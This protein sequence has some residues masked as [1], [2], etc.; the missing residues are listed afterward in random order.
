VACAVLLVTLVLGAFASEDVPPWSLLSS[1]RSLVPV[2]A[3]PVVFD[4]AVFRL[5]S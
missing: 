4:L 5:V 2:L 3:I 1:F